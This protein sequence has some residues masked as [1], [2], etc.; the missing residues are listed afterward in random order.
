MTHV[1]HPEDDAPVTRMDIHK[2][3]VWVIRTLWGGAVALALV[4]AWAV[5]LAN[6]VKT[7]SEKL[8]AKVDAATAQAI[9]ESLARIEK[10]IDEGDVRQRQ[11]IVDLASL[12]QKV[13]DLEEEIEEE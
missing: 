13:E 3:L 4:I 12:S 7:N 6:D 10:K 11:I 1:I 2:D 9:V 5:S 8:E